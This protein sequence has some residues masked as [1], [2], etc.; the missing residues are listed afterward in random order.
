MMNTD[1]FIEFAKLVGKLKEL[2]RFGWYDQAGIDKLKVES[3]ADHSY[4]CAMLATVLA[5]EAG[6]D[7]GKVS[8]MMLL[9]DLEE[10]ITGD[11]NRI[12]KEKED[13]EVVKARELKAFKKVISN[14]SIGL[15]NKYIELW[16]EYQTGE[17]AEA[18]L[19]QS[20]DRIDQ[21]IQAREYFSRY[22]D[23]KI[24]KK[25]SDENS[26]KRVSPETEEIVKKL[27]EWGKS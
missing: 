13:P 17:T 10:V 22:P 25:F 15:Q 7:S 14:L 6:L 23:K 2:K 3:V 21:A 11:I 20:I 16:K 12:E 9:H 5:D 1:K 18:K 26:L 4:R 19:C 8:K 24:L 27:L